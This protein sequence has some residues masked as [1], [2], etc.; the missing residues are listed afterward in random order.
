MVNWVCTFPMCWKE[1]LKQYEYNKD[2]DAAISLMQ[3]IIDDTPDELDS[4]LCMNYLL[5]DILVNEMYDNS[6]HG[7]YADLLKKYCLESYRRFSNNSEY[8]FY[9]GFIASMSE[10]YFGIEMEDVESMLKKAT[11]L[12]SE[13]LLYEWGYCCIPNQRAE[14]NTETKYSLSKQIL[15][16]DMLMK[17]ITKKGLLGEYLEEFILS[18]YESTRVLL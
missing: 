4:Y 17:N 18:V 1:Q 9:I 16:N 14:V 12:D 15:E 3:V 2:W 10:W 5:M 6:K 8:L 7:Y 13:S 11:N